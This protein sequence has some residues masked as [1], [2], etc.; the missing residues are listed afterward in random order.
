VSSLAQNTASTIHVKDVDRNIRE[1]SA[2]E[3]N[4]RE[5]R[6]ASERPS[7]ADERRYSIIILDNLP[8]LC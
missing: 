6:G 2:S 5:V 8:I 7:D 3:S 4:T 1:E